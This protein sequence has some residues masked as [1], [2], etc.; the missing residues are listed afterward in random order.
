MIWNV[1]CRSALS[2]YLSWR[3]WEKFDELLL[4]L[5]L[6]GT[7]VSD[8]EMRSARRSAQG[9]YIWSESGLQA[10]AGDDF[11]LQICLG[12]DGGFWSHNC[13][14]SLV[15]NLELSQRNRH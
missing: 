15:G 11:R 2:F 3:V 13:R 12:T 6:Q 9:R 10:T 14:R 8:L 7:A 5:K 1:G 4:W